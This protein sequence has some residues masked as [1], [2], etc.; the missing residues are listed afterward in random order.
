[1]NPNNPWSVK[2]VDPEAR[3]L[4]KK[5]ARAA[6]M[7]LGAWLTRT[8]GRTASSELGAGLPE[9]SLPGIRAVSQDASE[10]LTAIET[11]L[12]SLRHRLDDTIAP[13]GRAVVSMAHRL[14]AV[15]KEQ[16]RQKQMNA[17]FSDLTRDEDED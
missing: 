16:E 9:R 17:M 6:G 8:I 2:N 4:A 11:R 15:E 1:M 12:E 3:A 13:I 7:T 10:S 5:A 14:E